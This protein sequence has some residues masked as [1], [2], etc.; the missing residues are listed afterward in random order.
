MVIPRLAIVARSSVGTSASTFPA[1][2]GET[3]PAYTTSSRARSLRSNS[4]SGSEGPLALICGITVASPGIGPSQASR[5]VL[6]PSR[7]TTAGGSSRTCCSSKGLSGA[8]TH[9][10]GTSVST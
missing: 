10:V 9:R 3:K 6:L 7:V 5:L 1:V 8:Y 4:G 2:I